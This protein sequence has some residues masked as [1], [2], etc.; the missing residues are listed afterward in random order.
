MVL[1]H[2]LLTNFSYKVLALILFKLPPI[3]YIF[4]AF[5][6]RCNLR[7]LRN[8]V[9][10]ISCLENA[11]EFLAT[12]NREDIIRY[13][14]GGDFFLI[15]NLFF[16]NLNDLVYGMWSCPYIMTFLAEIKNEMTTYVICEKK[17]MIK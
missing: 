5:F 15:I 9:D 11:K 6:Y 16:E 14:R 4:V 13:D 7:D 3:L 10:Q 8:I 17:V 1:N 12:L 2:I